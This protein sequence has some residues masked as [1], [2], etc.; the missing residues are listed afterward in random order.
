MK[1][2]IPNN[3]PIIYNFFFCNGLFCSNVSIIV[4]TI[5]NCIG[6]VLYSE[7]SGNCVTSVNIPI[8]NAIGN[9]KLVS[10]F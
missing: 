5:Y 6:N 10:L 2:N 8:F 3:N 4:Y 7:Q 1:N 9:I